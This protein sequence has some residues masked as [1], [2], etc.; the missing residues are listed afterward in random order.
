MTTN[1]KRSRDTKVQLAVLIAGLF[2]FG[3]AAPALAQMAPHYRITKTVKLGAPDRWDYLLYDSSMN[4]VYVSHG[5]VITV[6]DAASGK[7]IGNIKGM[8][9]G[10]HGIAI[11]TDGNG[12]TVDGRAAQAVE[13]N[14]KTL[15]VTKR[16]KA[17]KDADGVAYDPKSDHVFV[18][19]GDPGMVT[20]ID[21]KT[22]RH[23]A[24]VNA[25][26]KVEFLVAGDN[27]KLYVNGNAKNEIVRI[28][29][30][31]NKADAHWPMPGCRSP[32]GLAIDA[33]NHILFSTCGNKKGIF[34]DANTGHVI[35]SVP[36]GEFSDAAR[37][38]PVHK[39]FFSSNFDGT[40]DIFA[41]E[42]HDQFKALPP[43][44]TA[45]GARTMAINPKNGR[46]F[47]TT[48]DYKVNKSVP[49]TDRRHRYSIVPGST[50][51]LVLDRAK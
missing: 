48:A 49:P 42:G 24:N 21:G 28:D 41:E 27:G 36:I 3:T 19:D 43:V 2:S 40:L 16:I 8:P 18:A 13:F 38:D 39:L 34:M 37:F 33:A 35:D 47:M 1:K 30:A 29:I 5:S 7:I 17:L 14:P 46:I 31:T 45:L 6:V 50:K 25:G 4:R 15:K 20:V 11:T 32:H 12:F 10:T 26:G 22:G 23:I 51:L 44:K 9:G